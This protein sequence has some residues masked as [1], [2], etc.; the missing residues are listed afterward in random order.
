VLGNE[1]GSG[2]S[3]VAFAIVVFAFIS[4]AMSVQAAATR[5]VFSFA[6]D[7]MI[8]GSRALSRVHPRFHMPPGALAVS[9]VIP[10]VIA[11]MPSATVARIVTFA[12]VGI[13]VGFQAVVLA[14][15][16]AR[17]RGWRPQGA[18]T[19]G[20]WGLPVNVLALVYGVSAIVILSIKTPATG[21]GFLNRWLV[22]ISL[23]VVAAVGLVYMLIARP[24]ETIGEEARALPADDGVA[25]VLASPAQA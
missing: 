11:F 8:V 23:L 20:S 18:F 4:A 17:S 2:G 7:G 12:V 22:P 15:L 25:G 9:A 5:L 13:Y 10:M 21:P 24:Q 16:I 6:R 14:S 3:K 19:L 1:L